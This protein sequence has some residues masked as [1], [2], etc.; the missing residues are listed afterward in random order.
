MYRDMVDTFLRHEKSQGGALMPWT[1]VSIVDA[2]EEFCRLGMT[3]DANVREL[4]R[5]FG[6]SPTTGYLWLS[7]YQQRGR[8]RLANRSRQPRTSPTKTPGVVEEAVVDLRHQH[9]AWGSRKMR[10]VLQARGVQGVP[11]A[12]TVTRILHRRDLLD[13]DEA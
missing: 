13:P 10:A 3:E 2:R 12:S 5:R 1:E 7:R 9:P 8:D 6:I 11:T 4:C